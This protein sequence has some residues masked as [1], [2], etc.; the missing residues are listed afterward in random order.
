MAFSPW[1]AVGGDVL[2]FQFS[3]RCIEIFFLFICFGGLVSY[4]FPS[5]AEDKDY[6]SELVQSAR[7]KRLAEQAAWHAL[8]HY[9]PRL[10]SQGIKSLVDADSFFIAPTGKSDPEAELEATL[11]SFFQQNEIDE[12]DEGWQCLFIARYH[13]LKQA[14]KFDPK[15]LPELAC[16]KFHQWMEELNPQGLTLIFPAAYMN[17]PASMFGHTLLRID[18]QEQDKDTRLLAYTVNFAAVTNQQRGI[19]FAL[20]GLFGGYPGKFSIAPYYLKVKEYGDIENRDIWEYKLNFTK[21]EV[22]QLLRHVWEMRS[23]YFDYYFLDENCSYQLLSLLE[24]ARPSLYLTNSFSRWAI[25]GETVRAVVAADLVEEV[26]FRP[27]RITILRERA[28]LMEHRLQK[29]AKG[30]AEGKI[31]AT[32][33]AVQHLTLAQQAQVLELALDYAAYRRSS[34]EEQREQSEE[35]LLALLKIRS[36]LKL[37]DQTPPA[38]SEDSEKEKSRNGK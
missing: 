28:R 1:R 22:K 12:L 5:L 7:Q 18:G 9:K 24:V 14:L 33:A 10:A 38:A 34:E 20:K 25:P 31:P 8:L 3:F 26:F 6:L 4:S 21:E 2:R 27:A 17:N 35:R 15:R 16:L 11:T 37:P 23:A 29:L 30:L 32:G 19:N 36:Q 13:W